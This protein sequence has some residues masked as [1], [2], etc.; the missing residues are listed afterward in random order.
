LLD[1]DSGQDTISFTGIMTRIW[2]WGH[3]PTLSGKTEDL[4]E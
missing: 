3:Q 4:K 1:P 2:V